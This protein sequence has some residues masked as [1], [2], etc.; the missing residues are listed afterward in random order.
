MY[1]KVRIGAERG[2]KRHNSYNT[3][4]GSMSWHPRAHQL[5]DVAHGEEAMDQ[6]IF[7]GLMRGHPAPGYGVDRLTERVGAVQCPPRGQRSKQ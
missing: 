1:C 5:A 6:D 4:D 3:L 7:D 2:G